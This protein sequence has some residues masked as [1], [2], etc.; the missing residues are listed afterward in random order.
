MSAR[1]SFKAA[2]VEHGVKRGGQVNVSGA[3]KIRQRGNMVRME[4]GNNDSADVRWLQ[5][6]RRQLVDCQLFLAQGDRSHHPV[7]PIREMAGLVKKPVGIASIEQHC[8]KEGMLKE[9]EH[10]WETNI[11]PMSALDRNV[12]RAGT[13]SGREYGNFNEGHGSVH[14]PYD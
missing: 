9:R 11:A 2:Q 6:A 13:K 4:M 5:A 12:F 1:Q 3:G 7:Q 8:S 14:H 10:G